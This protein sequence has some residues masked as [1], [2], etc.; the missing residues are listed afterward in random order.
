M[1]PV[2]S[3]NENAK[4]WV[5]A[6]R[7]GLFQQGQGY[8]RKENDGNS[9]GVKSPDLFCCLGVACELAAIEGVNI[10]KRKKTEHIDG[11][12]EYDGST[13]LLPESVLEWLGLS[14][15]DGHFQLENH[16]TSSLTEMND[17]GKTFEEIA[18]FIERNPERL[19][20]Q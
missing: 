19:F 15:T 10:S 3:L 11:E 20:R 1:T 6:L 7:S 12:Y 4:K 2:I 8:L 16:F 18:D 9:E 14:S 17:S 5:R 13:G